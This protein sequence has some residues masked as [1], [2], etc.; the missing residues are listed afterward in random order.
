MKPNRSLT[1]GGSIVDGG[2]YDMPGCVTD[3]PLNEDI[4]A[5]C[6]SNWTC[7]Y[8]VRVFCCLQTYAGFIL[9]AQFSFCIVYYY[10]NLAAQ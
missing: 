9:C 5:Q 6:S 10:S 7:N 4:A 8:C 3:F 2:I 1:G